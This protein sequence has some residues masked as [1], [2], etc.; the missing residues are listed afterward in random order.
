M[1]SCVVSSQRQQRSS[2]PWSALQA[3]D[4]VHLRKD[5]VHKLSDALCSAPRRASSSRKCSTLILSA[6]VSGT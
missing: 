3:V 5:E 6:L 2:T 1:R 4:R